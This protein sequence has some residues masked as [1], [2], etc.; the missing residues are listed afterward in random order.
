[1]Q[2]K[3]SNGSKGGTSAHGMGRVLITGATSQLGINLARTLIKM[4]YE[5]RILAQTGPELY[6]E[7]SKLPPGVIPFVGDFT[8]KG[9]NDMNVLIDACRDVDVVFHVGGAEYN[10]KNTYAKLIETN[11]VGTENMITAYM[12]ANKNSGKNLRF[13][14]TSTTSVYGYKRPGEILTEDADTRPTHGYPESKL[15]A[16]KVINA[17]G[18]ANKSL[19]YTILRLSKLYGIGYESSFFKVFKLLMERKA[20]YIG[21]GGNHITLLHVDDAVR[22][23]VMSAQ[24]PDGANRVYNV[25]DGVPY[26]MK[27][28]L[29]LAAHMLGVEPPKKSVNPLLAR[30]IASREHGIQYDEFEFLTS[31]RIISIEKIK[32]ELG[33]IPSVKIEEGANELIDAFKKEKVGVYEKRQS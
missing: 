32:K 28:L 16:E 23:L 13:I 27:E 9:D 4:G 20:N 29:G 31:D 15:M 5:V 19:R 11:V 3:G 6:G 2:A 17:F 7:W 21:S 25:S 22:A 26:T 12:E 14:F 33:F 1:M 8:L 30:I 18:A 10:Y 24:E